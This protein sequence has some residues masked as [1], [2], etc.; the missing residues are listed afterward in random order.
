MDEVESE[1]SQP[2]VSVGSASTDTE[3]RLYTAILYKGLEHLQILVAAGVL[4]P[5]PCRCCGMTV[6]SPYSE[7]SKLKLVT[8]SDLVAVSGMRGQYSG[9]CLSVE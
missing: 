5:I 2:S 3:G 4:K 6:Y 9:K 8:S 7:C 1:Y